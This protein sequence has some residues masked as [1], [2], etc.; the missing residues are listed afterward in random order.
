[1]IAVIS[2]QI[3]LDRSASYNSN[4]FPREFLSRLSILSLGFDDRESLRWMKEMHNPKE[5]KLTPFDTRSITC[6]CHKRQQV[7]GT[8]QIALRIPSAGEMLTP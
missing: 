8:M 2:H 7:S 4:N 5:N 1:M 3:G 6:E